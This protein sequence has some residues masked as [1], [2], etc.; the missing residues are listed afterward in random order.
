MG[1]NIAE[2]CLLFFDGNAETD[3][4]IVNLV[5]AF[6]TDYYGRL[7]RQDC[8]ELGIDI[9]HSVITDRYSTSFYLAILESHHDMRLGMSDMR[10]LNEMTNEVIENALKPVK[11]GDIVVVD[12]NFNENQLSLIVNI[13][14][15]KNAKYAYAHNKIRIASDPVSINKIQ[16][17]KPIISNLSFFKPNRIE[18]EALTGIPIV[19]EETAKANLLWFL[20]HGVEEI[21]ITMA[22]KGVL[23][24]YNVDSTYSLEWYTHR[25]IELENANG[26]G[27]SFK[28]AYLSQRIKGVPPKDAIKFA[29]GAAVLTIE[30]PSNNRR[31]LNSKMVHSAKENLQIT[32][33]QL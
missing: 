20:E 19:D 4:S 32:I 14:E 33:K 17:L 5:T 24:G 22:E 15:E 28:G 23:L 18:S 13:I 31:S 11:P 27:D 12:T 16:R 29:I 10:I 9:N 3:N 1:R 6:S 25:V 7:L 26:G 2:A 8:E 30:T 21:I